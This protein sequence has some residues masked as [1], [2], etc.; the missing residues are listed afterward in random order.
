M[1]EARAAQQIDDT[2]L[3]IAEQLQLP[4]VVLRALLLIPGPKSLAPDQ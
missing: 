1:F 2:R 3:A 4:P